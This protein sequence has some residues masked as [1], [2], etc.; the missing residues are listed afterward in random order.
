MCECLNKE[1]KVEYGENSAE[2]DGY[3]T[4]NS[5]DSCI[6]PSMEDME[7]GEF[8]RRVEENFEQLMQAADATNAC[9]EEPHLENQ[10]KRSINDEA[11]H[12]KEEGIKD[13]LEIDKTTNKEDM[14]GS[15]NRKEG[16]NYGGPISPSQQNMENE[17][18]QVSGIAQKE[19]EN[20]M[21]YYQQESPIP[22]NGLN[23]PN[24]AHY[25][26]EDQCFMESPCHNRSE[27]RNEELET[28][29]VV[30]KGADDT[31]KEKIKEMK[32]L[33]WRRKRHV[34]TEIN[35]NAGILRKEEEKINN[36]ERKEE[37]YEERKET[38][39]KLHL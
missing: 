31:N 33:N 32:S 8:K 9:T 23:E 4:E 24:S 25:M 38:I 5:D 29:Q 2:D 27:S 19:V 39:I 6:P 11:A 15:K 16:T 36:F 3:D 10:N 20:G 7:E 18:N 1:Q 17:I 26:M 28:T 22:S 12:E 14:C 21:G 37:S 35:H 34:G 30:Q 13:T